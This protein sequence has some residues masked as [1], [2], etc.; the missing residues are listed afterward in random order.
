MTVWNV[1]TPSWKLESGNIMAEATG[2]I[3]LLTV[4]SRKLEEFLNEVDNNHLVWLREIEEEAKR[5]F[6]RPSLETTKEEIEEEIA[7]ETSP[8][9]LSEITDL[10]EQVSKS[11]RHSLRH[12]SA[13][14]IA[15][16]IPAAER[17]GINSSKGS[18][19]HITKQNS[20]NKEN[21]AVQSSATEESLSARRKQ[22]YKRAVNEIYESPTDEEKKLDEDCSPPRKKTPSPPCPSSK[23][24]RPNLKTFLHTVQKNQLLMT[25]VSAGRG[26][27]KSFIKRNTPVKIDAKIISEKE[28]QRLEMLKKKEEA[29][30]LRKQKLEEEK[31]RRMEEA[32]L[33][34]EERMRKVLQARERVEKIEEEKKKK[35][36]NKFAQIDEKSEKIREERLAEEKAKKKVAAKKME[37]VETRRRQEEESR[38]QKLLQLEEEERK[39]Q[40]M[41][42]R[43]KE[44]EELE[45]QRKMAEAKKQ[46]ELRQAEIERER[47]REQQLAAEKEIE[48]KKELER[49]K[50][51]KERERQEKEK[52]LQ[53][54]R[55]LER[56]AREEAAAREKERLRKEM[57]ERERKKLEEQRQATLERQRQE[58]LRL[59]N[60]RKLQESLEK[61]GQQAKSASNKDALNVTMDVPAP[62]VCQSYQMTPKGCDPKPPKINPNNYG[63]DLNSDDSTDDEGAPRKPI[64]SWAEGKLLMQAI[65]RQYYNPPDHQSYFGEVENPKLEE[66]FYKSKPRY[67]KRTSSA[68][69]NSPPSLGNRDNFAYTLKKF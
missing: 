36:E 48:R 54:Q 38:K 60:E 58:K 34:R 11:P 55:E 57:E 2:P 19:D 43:K 65:N 1:K 61:K 37:E 35:I 29:E 64:P 69:W 3:P 49:I 14:K 8:N 56:S 6:T 33:K 66:I 63:M 50:A 13:S 44:D 30:M 18:P 51:E 17:E 32:R 21:N 16:S 31:K 40:E 47:L 5:M 22:S 68:V 24:L 7:E 9:I 27:V 62:S 20:P 26:V 46:A 39:H 67:N 45:K 10:V 12:H 23:I 41:L 52:A 53:L 42:Q 28:K 25:P 59:E 15:D 4:L